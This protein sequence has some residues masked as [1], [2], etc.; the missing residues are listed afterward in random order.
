MLTNSSTGHT[1]AVLADAFVAAGADVTL[2]HAVQAV[3]PKHPA[4]ACVS[5]VTSA[6][7]DA[8]CAQLLGDQNF[9]LMIHAAAVSDFVVSAVVSNGRR[10]PA[11]IRH[12]LESTAPLSIEMVPGKKILPHLKDYSRNP[13]LMLVGFK[14]TDGASA[15]EAESAIQKVLNAGADV[16]IHNDTQQMSTSRA[17]AWKPGAPPIELPTLTE[18]SRYLVGL[19]KTLHAPT[20]S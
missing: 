11:P 18:L 12:K 5:Y 13:N 7:L 17:V 16:V 6:D 14:L 2:I 10:F 19:G 4:V 20:L 1:G 15:E 8:A 3:R 9:D